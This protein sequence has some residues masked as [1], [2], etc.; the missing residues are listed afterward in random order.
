MIYEERTVLVSPGN[1]AA[2]ADYCNNEYWPSLAR[3]GAV[4]I[5]LLGGMIGDPHNHFVQMTRFPDLE[6]W[7]SAQSEQPSNS[8]TFM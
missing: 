2:Y 6:T 5:A 8:M 7:S 3:H 1:E 4:P